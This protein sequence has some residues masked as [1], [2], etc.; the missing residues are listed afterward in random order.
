MDKNSIETD[1]ALLKR[2]TAQMAGVFSK[3]DDAIDK[4]GDVA[5]NISKMLAV[6]EEKLVIHERVD[7]ELFEL[8]EKRRAEMQE[9]NKEIHS[10]ITTIQREIA[11]ELANTEHKIMEAIKEVKTG[12]EANRAANQKDSKELETRIEQLERWRW[13]LVGG[14]MVVGFIVTKLPSVLSHLVP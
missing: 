2:D 14:G 10:R 7:R 12:V 11:S 5:N 6:H 3:L 4:L 8:V 9:D 1:V 13:I